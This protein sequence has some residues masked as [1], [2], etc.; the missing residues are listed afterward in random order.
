M[1][2][3][4]N[5]LDSIIEYVFQL[6]ENLLVEKFDGVTPDPGTP[7]EMELNDFKKKLKLFSEHLKVKMI[8]SSVKKSHENA[9]SFS[10]LFK[11]IRARAGLSDTDFDGVLGTFKHKYNEI[12]TRKIFPEQAEPDVM[13]GIMSVL[14]LKFHQFVE[15]MKKELNNIAASAGAITDEPVATHG[16]IT[17]DVTPPR[18]RIIHDTYYTTLYDHLNNHYKHLLKDPE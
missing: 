3:K 14:D 11:N 15:L 12:E 1:I 4:N 8:Q 17:T 7:T 2:E 9:S 16:T 6:K 5:E 10:D 13:A 18:N